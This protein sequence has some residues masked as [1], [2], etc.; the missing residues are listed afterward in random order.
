[1]R[2]LLHPDEILF[3]HHQRRL[4]LIARRALG[5]AVEDEEWIACFDLRAALDQERLERAAERAGDADEF[6]LDISLEP[7]IVQPAAGGRGEEDAGAKSRDGT[8]LH[9][10]SLPVS[11]TMPFR[12]TLMTSMYASLGERRNSS[13][14]CG[15]T[16]ASV[17]PRRISMMT[18]MRMSV[19]TIPRRR[20]SA[21]N[22]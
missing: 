17:A 3:R 9:S 11:V 21:K 5:R 13:S 1:L 22:L 19:R 20:A 2:E 4:R 14:F 7:R 6:A 18:S 15:L 16:S 8:K 12:T 10:C